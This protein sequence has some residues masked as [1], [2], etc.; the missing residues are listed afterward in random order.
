LVVD[1]L[2]ELCLAAV[3]SALLERPAEFKS[4]QVAVIGARED[5]ERAAAIKRSVGIALYERWLERGREVDFKAPE[6]LFRLEGLFADEPEPR[7]SLQLRSVYLYGR[8]C[9]L[10]RGISQSRWLCMR[11]KGRGC[12]RCDGKGRFYENSVHELLSGVAAPAFG[13]TELAVF[14]GMGREDCNVLMLGR[15]RPFVLEI[16]DPL[17]RYIDLDALREQVN[18]DCESV[19]SVR[20]LRMVDRG[21]P[22]RIKACAP[23]KSYQARCSFP[24]AVD[25]ADSNSGSSGRVDLASET[26]GSVKVPEEA[27][28]RALVSRF[29]DQVLEQRTPQRVAGRRADL[30]RRRTVRWLKLGAIGPQDFCCSLRTESGTYIKEFISGDDGR[31]SPSIAAELGVPCVCDQLDVLNIHIDDDEA[32][33]DG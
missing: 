18:R 22:A 23:D 7:C 27:A 13:S 10:Q 1:A 5:P 16:F 9:K 30:V 20:S 2:T 6:V 24:A 32:L 31:T 8:Y 33:G 11:C 25:L 15:G 12:R 19:V 17:K 21:A 29:R 4:F 3:D 14:H 28:I 26:P